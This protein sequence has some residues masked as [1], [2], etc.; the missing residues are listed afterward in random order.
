MITKFAEQSRVLNAKIKT[1][2]NQNQRTEFAKYAA[3]LDNLLMYYTYTQGHARRIFGGLAEE[4]IEIIQN[5]DTRAIWDPSV[6][7]IFMRFFLQPEYVNLNRLATPVQSW[8]GPY[9]R[10]LSGNV[11]E[12]YFS[13]LISE[14][15]VKKVEEVA[16][17]N[18]DIVEFAKDQTVKNILDKEDRAFY[19]AIYGL[20][21]ESEEEMLG[22]S[23]LP[24]SMSTFSHKNMIDL[25]AKH[26]SPAKRYQ[27]REFIIIPEVVYLQ[28]GKLENTSINNLSR[29][30]WD[31]GFVE[32]G[33]FTPLYKTKA[34]RVDDSSYVTNSKYE[35]LCRFASSFTDWGYLAIAG[36][37]TTDTYRKKMEFFGY[38][39]RGI[40]A[41]WRPNFAAD[42]GISI[43][44]QASKKDKKFT[45]VL[46]LGPRNFLGKML[47][48]GSDIKTNIRYENEFVSFYSAEH[49]TFLFHNKYAVTALDLFEDDGEK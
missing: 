16:A 38:K 25:M 41:A 39:T 24:A 27:P 22:L 34:M 9:M 15:I 19:T 46:V 26:V 17:Y 47:C 5:N 37:V 49:V 40:D 48:W 35:R 12:G 21:R 8:A 1:A 44:T 7:R 20:I 28:F 6:E 11:V 42:Y 3:G 33:P 29:D 31:N 30:Y 36:V 18:F 32:E 43:G 4:P 10:R 45:R 14:E 13:K 2:I 23:I